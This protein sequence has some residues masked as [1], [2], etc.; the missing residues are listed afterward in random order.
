MLNSTII[1]IDDDT[2]ILRVVGLILRKHGFETV[3]LSSP[4]YNFV[5]EVNTIKPAVILLDVQLGGY[6]GRELGKQIKEVKDMAPIAIT[7]FSANNYFKN[8]VAAYLCDDFIE[9][10]FTVD[11]FIDK[12]RYYAQKE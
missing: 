12:I 6:D 3:I 11:F 4:S 2:D 10:Q 1:V 5:K 7:L 9:K 8:D